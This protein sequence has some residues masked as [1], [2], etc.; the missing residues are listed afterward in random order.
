MSSKKHVVR[1]NIVGEEHAIRSDSPPEHTQ[2]VAA[3]VDQTIRRIRGTAPVETHRVAILAAMQIADE[4]FRARADAT[5][6][7][8]GLRALSEDVRRLLP[9]AKRGTPASVEAVAEE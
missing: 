8:A 7:L 6:L 5:E 2:A 3:Y 1:V 9:P 4:L